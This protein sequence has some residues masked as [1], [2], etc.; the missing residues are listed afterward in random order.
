MEEKAS[1]Q[2]SSKKL[3]EISKR[4]SYY[5]RHHLGKL[6]CPVTPDGYVPLH[7]LLAKREFSGVT[8]EEIESIVANCS[9]QRFSLQRMSSDEAG[10]EILMI[11]AN[12]GHSIPSATSSGIDPDQIYHLITEPLDYCAHG[13]RREA[14]EGIQRTGLNRMG[15][16]HIHFA[17]KPDAKSGFR[18]DSKVAIHIDMARAMNDGIKFYRSENDVILSDGIDGVIDPKYISRIEFV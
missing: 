16:T 14:V 15:R 6:H 11:R 5:L 8:V 2:H 1:S 12:Q 3:T 10:E 7:C 17:C 9:K 13:T 4:M 18:K